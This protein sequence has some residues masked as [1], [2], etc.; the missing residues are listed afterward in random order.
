MSAQL[1]P[2]DSQDD[3]HVLP[4][5]VLLPLPGLILRIFLVQKDIAA[6]F[7]ELLFSSFVLGYWCTSWVDVHVL[8]V[9][10]GA[11]LRW[12]RAPSLRIL[13]SPPRTLCGTRGCSII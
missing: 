1:E 8:R 3:G 13:L 4:L 10:H 12:I 9:M 5:S 6:W 2:F 11:D 7:D